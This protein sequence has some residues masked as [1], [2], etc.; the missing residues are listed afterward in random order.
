MSVLGAAVALAIATAPLSP[1]E[2]AVFAA[3]TILVCLIAGRCP[4]RTVNLLLASL[5]V[6]V[7]LRYIVW[8]VSST[9]PAET[10]LETALAI[11]LI[12]AEL[13][14]IATLILGYIQTAGP[15]G[16]APSPLPDDPHA[17]PTVDVFIPTV[18]E[19]LDLVRATVLAA[20]AMD[21][22]PDALRV[23]L[24]DDGGRDEFRQF[25]AS[26]GC[27]YLARDDHGHAKAGN[28]NHALSHSH[29]EFV[30]V[31]DCDHVPTRAFLQLT[32]GSIVAGP[33]LA[34]V[35]TPQHCYSPDPFQRNLGLRSPQDLLFHGLLQDGNDTWNATVFTGSCAVLRRTALD[36]IGGFA[37]ETVT[38]DVHT[39]LKL[40][41][42]GWDSAYLRIPL[43]GGLAPER[44]SAAIRQRARWARG[45]MQ[46]L[47][48][49]NPLFGRGLSV[50]QRICYLQVSSHF[51]FAVPR[52]AF[53]T[54]PLA[55]LLFGLNVIAASPLAIIAY[56][57][58]HIF[59]ALA[60]RSRIEGRW[61]RTLWS[62]VYETVFALSLVGPTFSALLRPRRGRFHPTPK[63]NRV[64]RGF[65]WRSTLPNIVLGSLLAGG[66]ARGAVVI[67]GSS[68]EHDAL[69]LQALTLN[70]VWAVVALA[71]VLVAI[72]AG[73]ETS[74]PRRSARISA[75]LPVRVHW[76]GGWVDGTTRDLSRGGA[77]ID[78]ARPAG[79]TDD[80][81]LTIVTSDGGQ[82]PA[83]V[84]RWTETSLHLSWSPATLDEEA[85][86]V[87]TVFGRAD[88]WAH[89]AT[90]MVI[91]L[92]A[93]L[94]VSV[95]A[96]AQTDT[97][98][99][100]YTLHQLGAS[101]PVVLRGT[102]ERQDIAF[103]LRADE[104]VIAAQLDL[105]GALSPNLLPEFSN[106]TVTV[107]DQYVGT[108]AADRD[109]PNFS[110][111]M[112]V[113]PVFLQDRNRL[114]FRFSG[115]YSPDC[116]DPL[117]GLLWATV[118]DGSTLTLTVRETTPT[119]ELAR[120]PSPLFD[121]GQT[122][123]LSLPV[124]LPHD[125]DDETLNAAAIAA[126]WFGQQSGRHGATFSTLEAA[127]PRGN[128]VMVA[129]GAALPG[130]PPAGGPTLSL[131]ANPNDAFS[132]ILVIAGRNAGET[133]VAATALAL[134]ETKL[135]SGSSAVVTPV[136]APEHVPYDAPN[137]IPTTRAVKLGELV[138]AAA[139]QEAGYVGLLRVPFRTA[140]DFDTEDD[141][142]FPL[143]I[144]F[145][146]PPGSVVD[147]ASS[148]LDV[149][150]NGQYLATAT[151]GAAGRRQIR[152]PAYDVHGANDLEFYFDARPLRHGGD[153]GAVP[154]DLRMSVDPD[155]TID[156]SGGIRV[157]ALPNLASFVGSGFP[158]TRMADLSETAIVAA[159]TAVGRRTRHVPRCDG[160]DRRSDRHP[161]DRRIRRA[162]ARTRRGRRPRSAGRRHGGRTRRPRR[163]DGTR[164]A[165]DRGR[166]GDGRIA[167]RVRPGGAR[168]RRPVRGGSR[169][170]IGG[171]VGRARGR[172]RSAGRGRK[173]VHRRTIGG[174]VAGGGTGP[175]RARGG[176]VRRRPACA[177]HPGR[178]VARDR[179][180]DHVLPD[181]AAVHRRHAAILAVPALFPARPPVRHDPRRGLGRA[182]GR[183]RGVL[184]YAVARRTPSRVDT[185][186]DGIGP[187]RPSWEHAAHDRPGQHRRQLASVPPRTGRGGR[188]AR[189]PGRARRPVAGGR[190]PDRPRQPDAGR[191]QAR[192]ADAG[193]E[194]AM[195]GFRLG[196]RDAA[197]GRGP[198]RSDRPFRAAADRRRGRAAGHVA[199]GGAGRC[200]RDVAVGPAER[201]SRLDRAT[202]PDRGGRRDFAALRAGLTAQRGQ[203]DPWRQ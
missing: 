63:G 71:I 97:R 176:G 165:A 33:N 50:G 102:Q 95:A 57:L 83:Q 167:G 132:S 49:D 203:H 175:A 61:R 75:A 194:R 88:T 104:V 174:G 99:I 189:W 36:E 169:A 197:D 28:L 150:I 65:D 20:L 190:T 26:A 11:G 157:A 120:L 103:G 4:G 134:G 54:A 8:R 107:N 1:R 139:L 45:M 118:Y 96:H 38:E 106:V 146:G 183:G 48:V 37:V 3:G 202:H 58:P 40:H 5:S 112:P 144:A 23:W 52:I 74:Q 125:P 62:G 59:I 137:W 147:T 119:R 6:A 85:Q 180:R 77:L 201:R 164:P 193:H 31:F 154:G 43:A 68:P 191:R 192:R 13:Y 181:P 56:G 159:G 21:W 133:V 100:V 187:Q 82:L 149:G 93:L 111:A 98:T 55:Y 188:R 66:I 115:R 41:R 22:P 17:W 73:R 2:Q 29:A 18:N 92:A 113:N 110:R 177:A 14:A 168:A 129:V 32:M 67:A 198:R 117:S 128:A 78:A 148:R 72:V 44:L 34:L 123:A 184:G 143:D 130:M 179:H 15:L 108:I 9:V 121:A 141:R 156:L 162:A 126:S 196:C 81:R 27:V 86:V 42:R 64:A 155:S 200:L 90:G 161:G 70:T 199:L 101:G 24:L 53:L 51:L 76:S 47:R 163:G 182:A 109:K 166:P 195:G 145:R 79:V 185:A 171:A 7:S 87:D 173:P 124:I 158:F 142:G 152:I 80:A 16:R 114:G 131:V 69:R 135:L 30:C 12:V 122:D 172:H 19:P 10:P 151:L 138:D 160:P 39:M 46:I 84:V 170:G 127:P 153:C 25:A 105:T 94:G 35:Q 89:W 140:P 91:V 178:F 60:T 186:S 136:A 116:N